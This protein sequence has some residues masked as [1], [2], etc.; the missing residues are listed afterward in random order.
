MI[1]LDFSKALAVYS[2]ACVCLVFLLWL[3]GRK[4]K[5]KD[6]ALDPAYIWYCSVCTYTYINTREG[7]ISTCPRCS[8]FNKKTVDR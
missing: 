3:L 2:S 4:Q 8:S 5:D 6:L 7:H 1:N